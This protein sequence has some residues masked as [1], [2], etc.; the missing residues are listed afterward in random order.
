MNVLQLYLMY[1]MISPGLLCS[2]M[3]VRLYRLKLCISHCDHIEKYVT[4]K[5]LDTHTDII[6]DAERMSFR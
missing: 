1:C 3:C 5:G 6:T 2:M 4:S